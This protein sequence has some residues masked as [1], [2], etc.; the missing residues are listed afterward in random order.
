MI[1]KDAIV[2]PEP[3]KGKMNGLYIVYDSQHRI[4]VKLNYEN[5]LLNGDCFFYEN[6]QLIEKRPYVKNIANGWG[7]VYENEK[8][9]KWYFYKNGKR[10]ILLEL[11]G[12]DGL[13]KEKN[14]SSGEVVYIGHFDNDLNRNGIGYIFEE[15]KVKRSI[16]FVTGK[17]ERVL[18]EFTN[19][20]MIEYNTNGMKVYEGGYDDSIDSQF[21]RK[22]NGIEYMNNEKVYEGEWK[23]NKR[24]GV[25]KQFVHQHLEYFGL[26]KENVPHG[27]GILYN[28]NGEAEHSGEWNEGKLKTVDSVI[29]YTPEGIKIS[30]IQNE[31]LETP[32]KEYSIPHLLSIEDAKYCLGL[33]QREGLFVKEG[34]VICISKNE[35]GTYERFDYNLKTK[36]LKMSKKEENDSE[37]ISVSNSIT[38]SNNVIDLSNDGKRWE[39]CCLNGSPF[40]YG[41]LYNSSNELLYQGVM[42][43]DKKECFGIDF[44][45][46]LNEI[47][48][49]GCYYN[50]DRH[51]FGMLYDRKGELLYEGDFISGSSDFE[52]SVILE[53]IDNNDSTGSG[54]NNGGW[55]IVN[56]IEDRSIHSLIHELMI[57]EYGNEFDGDLLLCGFANLERL[58]VK[59]KSFQNVKRTVMNS[60]SND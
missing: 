56:D 38:E 24:D 15:N 19:D 51:G 45:P 37:F 13:K 41:S 43:R 40:G 49:I 58:V 6:N 10:V 5:N 20:S 60:I 17:E 11:V 32:H 57:E 21:C 26:W 8:E 46:A 14:M 54:D 33:F 18:K 59:K 52:T 39:G 29:E 36:E 44:Y 48:Y 50:N 31:V 22:G 3:I 12:E 55:V 25:G 42:I 9:V 28:S 30:G 27:Q 53:C 34:W 2:E 23:E 47:E 35:N 4:V 7:R 16:E 1:A